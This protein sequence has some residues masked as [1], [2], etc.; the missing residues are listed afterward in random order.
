MTSV[1]CVAKVSV[2]GDGD[3]TMIKTLLSITV[4]LVSSS[5]QAMMFGRRYDFEVWNLESEKRICKARGGE[6]LRETPFQYDH[7]SKSLYSI[8]GQYDGNSVLR[9]Y[10]LNNESVKCLS[11]PTVSRTPDCW[12]CAVVGKCFYVI[13]VGNSPATY[14]YKGCG[15]VLFGLPLDLG[16]SG[17]F[18]ECKDFGLDRFCLKL[19]SLSEDTLCVIGF[20]MS[21]RCYYIECFE[22]STFRSKSM[23]RF[24]QEWTGSS[25]AKL[26]ESKTPLDEIAFVGVPFSVHFSPRGNKILVHHRNELRLYNSHLD[27]IRSFDFDKSE[28]VRY[29]NKS[30]CAEWVDD[31]VFVVFETRD[32]DWTE[33]DIARQNVC[34]DGKVLLKKKR[35]SS[36]WK[37]HMVHAVGHGKFFISGRDGRCH[38]VEHRIIM[39]REGEQSRD[40]RGAADPSWVYY[41]APDVI[42]FEY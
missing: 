20:E 19:K 15:N 10:D 2:N 16:A 24:P 22:T 38:N 34:G 8:Q 6:G 13:G 5:S 14:M 25:A 4:L 11:I 7:A 35:Y 30:A 33:Y 17:R 23:I 27:N 31:D 1:S 28:F 21:T 9:S 42:V 37:E 12:S 29:A 36:D 39:M 18:T 3:R 40:F 41:F 26:C 32:G